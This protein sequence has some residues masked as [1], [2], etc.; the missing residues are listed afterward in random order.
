MRSNL[1]GTIEPSE[2]AVYQ[3]NKGHKFEYLDVDLYDPTAQY[4]VPINRGLF[5]KWNN[6]K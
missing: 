3:Q 4:I 2:F 6:T 5:G 1:H